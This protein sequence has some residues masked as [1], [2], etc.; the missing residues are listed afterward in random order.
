MQSRSVKATRK[1]PRDM[2]LVLRACPAPSNRRA[3]RLRGPGG[4]EGRP[5]RDELSA[6]EPQFSACRARDKAIWSRAEPRSRKT[7]G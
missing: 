2:C 6:A 1:P 5:G 7:N 3:T 4:R